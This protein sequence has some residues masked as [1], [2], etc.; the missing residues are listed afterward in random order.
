MTAGS[1]AS[2][3]RMLFSMRQLRDL[4]GLDAKRRIVRQSWSLLASR[5]SGC[6]DQGFCL[7]G[8]VQSSLFMRITISSGVR[9]ARLRE[10]NHAQIALKA[11]PRLRHLSD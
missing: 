6:F 2:G 7:Y 4:P 1:Q 8:S 9:H 10:S 5:L 3:H 11:Q